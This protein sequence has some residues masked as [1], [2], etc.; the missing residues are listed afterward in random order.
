VRAAVPVLLVLLV[1]GAASLSSWSGPIRWSADPDTLYY[2][3]KVLSFRGQNERAALYRLFA[4]PQGSGLRRIDLR[5]PPGLRRYTN[6]RWLNYSLSGFRRR[7]FVPLIAAG[8]YPLF[9]ERSLMDVSLIGYLLLGLAL[10]ALLRRRLSATAS[11]VATCICL[12]SAPLRKHSFVPMTDSWSVLLETGALLGA[13]L[14]L[15]RGKRWLPLW[16]VALAA[17]SFTRDVEVVPLVAVLGLCLHRNRRTAVVLAA[18]GVL[19]VLPAL[20]LF[21]SKA[22]GDTSPRAQL[23]FALNDFRPPRDSSWSFI[24]SHYW[25]S[26]RNLIHG[27]LLYGKSLGWQAP[28]W[29]LALGLAVI[30]TILLVRW[31]RRGDRFFQLIAYSL[32]GALGFVVLYG[33]YSFVREELVFLPAL[34]VALGLVIRDGRRLPHVRRGRLRRPAAEP[35]S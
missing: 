34:A 15:D 1:A 3:A 10:Y 6:R 5:Q 35:V 24:L 12:L 27:D 21:G 26:F 25:P 33:R 22:P 18:I 23:A 28:L 14:V 32:I 19:A 13:A 11:A 2:Q 9:G 4:G 8:L 29:Y 31:A 7:V 30:G 17:A 16:I 20:L